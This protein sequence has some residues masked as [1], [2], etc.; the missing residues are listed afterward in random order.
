MLEKPIYEEVVAKSLD[1]KIFQVK[2]V[3]DLI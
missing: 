1:L 3:L 2:V